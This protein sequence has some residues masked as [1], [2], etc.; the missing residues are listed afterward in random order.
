MLQPLVSTFF[1]EHL[2][3]TAS[4]SLSFCFRANQW[5]GFYMVGTFVVKELTES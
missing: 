1:D 4:D 5:P 3:R 2:P